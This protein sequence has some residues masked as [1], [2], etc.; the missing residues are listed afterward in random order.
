MSFAEVLKNEEEPALTGSP[1][2]QPAASSL[3]SAHPPPDNLVSL[4]QV[5]R[6]P[7]LIS[8]PAWLPCDNGAGADNAGDLVVDSDDDVGDN[9]VVT[10]KIKCDNE[11]DN[12]INNKQARNE[13]SDAQT[14][15]NESE[16]TI[17]DNDHIVNTN[18]PPVVDKDKLGEDAALAGDQSTTTTDDDEPRE[19]DRKRTPGKRI[20]KRRKHQKKPRTPKPPDPDIFGDIE[21]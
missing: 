6:K 18:L 16:Q 14:H 3:G 11:S 12:T 9:D 17:D 19:T 1:A 8:A 4:G 21:C 2:V 5:M 15:A 10:E 20:R 7:S 13:N